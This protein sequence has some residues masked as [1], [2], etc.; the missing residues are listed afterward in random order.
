MFEKSLAQIEY[1]K[2]ERRQKLLE[3]AIKANECNN[4]FNLSE[5][6]FN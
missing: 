5:G 1:E 2:E 4:N 3:M 6:N